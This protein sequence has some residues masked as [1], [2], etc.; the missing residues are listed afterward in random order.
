MS[1]ESSQIKAVRQVTLWGAVVNV[2][3]AL[4][5]VWAG[6]ITRSQALIADGVHS[7]SDL[8]TDVSIWVGVRYWDQ[9]PDECHPYG[10][11]RIETLVSVFIGGV[12]AF[13]AFELGNEAL[14]RLTDPVPVVNP[15]LI[16]TAALISVFS[17][18]GLFRWTV[19]VART[20]SSRALLANAWHHRSDALSSL[21]VLFSVLGM[22]IWPEHNYFDV[23]AAIV[24]VFMLLIASGKILI[25]ALGELVDK[26]A[27]IDSAWIEK[28]MTH[29][30][31]VLEIHKVRSRK[32]GGSVWLDF[33]MLV[34]ADMTVRDAHDIASRMKHHLMQKD[35]RLADVLIHVEPECETLRE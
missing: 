6:M 4:L 28:E 23:I 20:C 7:F 33:H 30:P 27:G 1:T 3:L 18:E 13:V 24:V 22:W 21:P 14:H 11:G 10:H 12:L 15:W 5:K 9:P 2:V 35:E 16:F 32:A 8:L 31:E 29:F 19:A 26:N 17:K 34:A 25:P